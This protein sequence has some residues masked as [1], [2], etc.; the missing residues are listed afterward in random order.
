MKVLIGSIV[1]NGMLYI[2]K[3]AEQIRN[4]KEAFLPYG[5]VD[6]IITENDSTDF[7]PHLIKK[8]LEPMGITILR[9][10]HGGPNFSS[11]ADE[12][13]RWQNI[14][15]TWNYML[16]HIVENNVEFD[17]FIYVES[18]L[19]WKPE[20]LIKLIYDLNWVDS[21]SPFTLVGPD[22]PSPLNRHP[23]AGFG[24]YDTYGMVKDGIH[25]QNY[26]PFHPSFK[27][28]EMIEIQRS[29]CC[30][31]MK[32]EVARKCRLSLRT[33][34]PLINEGGYSW[35]LDPTVKITHP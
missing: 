30:T 13:L 11:L 31:V 3:Y 2:P 34:M 29:G 12:P 17:V 20:A 6:V 21:V 28:D 32:G 18:D 14:A 25:F 35:W 8:H 7:T 24:F 15:K 10:S 23:S 9:Y 4:L 27:E 22:H 26:P 16:D 5:E 33:A 1:R 19:E